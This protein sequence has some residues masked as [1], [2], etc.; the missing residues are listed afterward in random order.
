VHLNAE[1]LAKIS[2]QLEGPATGQLI[3]DFSLVSLS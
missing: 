1:M 2:F 3:Q